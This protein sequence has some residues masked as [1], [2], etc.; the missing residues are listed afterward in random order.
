MKHK[1]HIVQRYKGGED[2]ESNLVELTPICH[3]MWHWC[4]WKLWGDYRDYCAHKMILGDV[5]N[6]EFRRARNE[7][8]K[9]KILEG[10]RKWREDNPDKVKQSGVKGNKSQREKFDRLG[11]TIAEQ[12]WVITTPDGEELIISNLA[13]FCREH[14]LLK[15]KMSEVAK[16]IYSQ[17][18]GYKVE[19]LKKRGTYKPQK[20]WKIEYPNGEEMIVKCLTDWCKVNDMNVGCM[21]R[22][23]RG[24]RDNHKGYKVSIIWN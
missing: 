20:F 18:K 24:E 13:E 5:K 16:G 1:H 8:F 3:S 6:P 2:C 22:V 15:H 7:A 9:D 4:E 12:E 23:G 14:N 19:K 21:T 11:R 17:H 10:G